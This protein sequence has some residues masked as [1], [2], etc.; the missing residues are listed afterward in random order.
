M[1]R[2][3]I[4]LTLLS[5]LCLFGYDLMV[6]PTLMVN[7]TDQINF[8]MPNR[9]LQITTVSKVERLQPFSLNI[10]IGLEKPL[11]QELKL[12]G[13]VVVTAPDGTQKTVLKNKEL[14]ALPAGA[15]GLIFSQSYL[16]VSFDP[17]DQNGKY[18]FTVTLKDTAGKVKKQSAKVELVDTVT[19]FDMMDFKEFDQLLTYY[20]QNP[21]PG[22]LLAALNYFLTEGVIKLRSK[23]KKANALPVLWC[24]AKI[25]QHNP[26][27]FD[28]LAKMSDTA[29]PK[30]QYLAILFYTI[31]KEFTE[32][33]KDKINPHILKQISRYKKPVLSETDEIKF[34]QQL[35]LLWG[36]FFAT[37]KFSAIQRIASALQKKPELSIQEAKALTASGKKL[38]KAQG[39]LLINNVTKNAAVWS[40]NSNIRRG[41]Q[42]LAGFYLETIYARKLYP[43]EQAALL[44]SGILK[45]KKS[46]QGNKK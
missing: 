26:Q 39:Q 46:T 40:L 30:D 16:S 10:A 21:Q 5:A 7:L 8:V 36:E 32:S 3:S 11:E 25:F 35:D 42:L 19:N 34:P 38:T 13:D 9:G 29:R 31:G 22:R 33:Y 27:F 45:N 14:F 37:G 4:I 43:D 1:K 41:G 23:G 24:F 28:E 12:I 17:P 20:Y 6:Y 18:Q 15:R 2:L 44:I